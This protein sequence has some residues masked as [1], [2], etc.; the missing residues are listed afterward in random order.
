VSKTGTLVK[1]GIPIVVQRA[2][3]ME[4]RRIDTAR[5]EILMVIE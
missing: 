1:R 2:R 3:G 5:K 4:R